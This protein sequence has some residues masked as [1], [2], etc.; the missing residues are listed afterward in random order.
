VRDGGVLCPECRPREERW[1]PARRA[2][3]ESLAR[4]TDGD[5]PTRPMDRPL[6]V[7]IRQLL[8]VCAHFHLERE[9]RSARFVRDVITRELKP[10]TP[11]APA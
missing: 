2:A 4:F 3:L 11:V 5:M 8:D 6:V 1:F 9:L 7:E 10:A